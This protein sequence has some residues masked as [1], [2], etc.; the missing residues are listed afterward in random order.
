[1]KITA[2]FDSVDSAE[3]AAMAVRRLGEGVFDVS[4]SENRRKVHR[5]GDFAPMGLFTNLNTGT[6]QPLGV[7]G[8]ISENSNTGVSASATVD[9]ICRPSEAK[10]V[11]SLLMN[12][13][14][15]DIKAK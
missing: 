10:K 4:L 14:G 2:K 9:I 11:V 7:V 8:N 15:H 3:F 12:G 5:D 1:M 6:L 13:G